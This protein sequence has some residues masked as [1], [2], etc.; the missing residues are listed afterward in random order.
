MIT[1]D[2]ALANLVRAGIVS[3]N[4]ARG[5]SIREGELRRLIG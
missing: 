5:Y 2:E 1:L 4:D 3:L